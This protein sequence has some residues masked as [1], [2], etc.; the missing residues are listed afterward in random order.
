MFGAAVGENRPVL[1]D[2][3]PAPLAGVGFVHLKRR[4]LELDEIGLARLLA[5][6]LDRRRGR[7]GIR[8]RFVAR[9]DDLPIVGDEPPV[10]L[11]FLLVV[12]LLDD[13]A[14]VRGR[15]LPSVVAGRSSVSS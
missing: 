2:E 11:R 8:V 4:V 10:P 9:G 5:D 1:V 6:A 12:A 14:A 15:F 7:L 3:P 13:H